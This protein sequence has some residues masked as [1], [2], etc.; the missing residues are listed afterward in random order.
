MSPD[1]DT[2]CTGAGDET[3]RFWKIYN[4]N[5]KNNHNPLSTLSSSEFR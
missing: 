3:L 4:N 1:G 2:I 5:L